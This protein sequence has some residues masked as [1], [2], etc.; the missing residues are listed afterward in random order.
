V[1]KLASQ[2][3]DRIFM[4]MGE[5]EFI[6]TYNNPYSII[7]NVTTGWDFQDGPTIQNFPGSNITHNYT[8]IGERLVWATPKFTTRHKTKSFPLQQAIM[9]EGN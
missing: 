2:M 9:V 1:L 5:L 4:A 8:T 6:V 3:H 7:K